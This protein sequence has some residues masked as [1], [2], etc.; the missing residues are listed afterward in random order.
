VERP[1]IGAPSEPARPRERDRTSG[2]S[3]LEVLIA[4]A[5]FATL[6]L[7][8]APLFV[9]A[10]ILQHAGRGSTEAAHLV[11]SR[12]EELLSLSW[13]DPALSTQGSGE[14]ILIDYRAAGSLQWSTQPP[15][16]PLAWVRSTALRRFAFQA[17]EDGELSRSEAEPD[18]ARSQ[19][20]EIEIEVRS[21]QLDTPFGAG[22]RTSVRLLR[23][24]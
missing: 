3:L 6:A 11:H 20:L 17:L 2:F 22:R 24:H 21:A 4:A 10:A 13:D 15:E 9:R 23:A 12:A 14:R 5:I 19:L 18:A 7:G 16:T 8:V 1:T